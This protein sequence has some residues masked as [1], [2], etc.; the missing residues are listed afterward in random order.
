MK[1]RS[2]DNPEQ[3]KRPQVFPKKS[4]FLPGKKGSERE[5]ENG[6]EFQQKRKKEKRQRQTFVVSEMF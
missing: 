1:C 2:G 4:I 6:L 5:R 3:N